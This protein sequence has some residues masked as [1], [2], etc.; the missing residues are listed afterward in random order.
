MRLINSP[1]I[2]MLDDLLESNYQ[3]ENYSQKR[4]KQIKVRS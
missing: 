2:V 1:Y 4:L 3:S